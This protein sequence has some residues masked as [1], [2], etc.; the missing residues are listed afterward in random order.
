MSLS[1]VAA[2]VP[3][4]LLPMAMTLSPVFTSL[5]LPLTV[6]VN[7]VLPVVWT[8]TVDV[9]PLRS[10]ALTVMSAPSTF[11]TEPRVPLR[12]PPGAPLP[13]PPPLPGLV[14]LFELVPPAVAAFAVPFDAPEFEERLRAN[15]TP[16]AITAVTMAAVTQVRHAARGVS[17]SGGGSGSFVGGVLG[18]HP[19]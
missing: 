18:S 17:V 9:V 7:V 15:P 5:K 3:D 11:V 1:V 19:P 16:P 12:K 10:V 6:W 2:I 13:L 14:E 8:T 4:E